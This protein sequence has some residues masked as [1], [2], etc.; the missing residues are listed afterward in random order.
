MNSLHWVKLSHNRKQEKAETEEDKG[1]KERWKQGEEESWEE[2]KGVREENHILQCSKKK[3]LI[4]RSFE[5]RSRRNITPPITGE[6]KEE[7]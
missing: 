3:K 2:K 1:R 5:G 7:Y 4:K 6:N